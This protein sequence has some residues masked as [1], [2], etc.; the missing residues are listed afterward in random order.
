MKTKRI[1]EDRKVSRGVFSWCEAVLSPQT[2]LLTRHSSILNPQFSNLTPQSSVLGPQFSVWKP[3]IFV[4]GRLNTFFCSINIELRHFCCK[5]REKHNIRVLR[6]KFWGNLNE[7]KPQV[8]QPWQ[9]GT[10]LWD[11]ST[12]QFIPSHPIQ[13]FQKGPEFRT[14]SELSLKGIFFTLP[15]SLTVNIHA[16]AMSN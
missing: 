11:T 6:I 5:C 14:W 16:M 12:R 10:F 13:C 1:Y 15:F 3:C 4:A 8:V 2:S 9:C 7:D